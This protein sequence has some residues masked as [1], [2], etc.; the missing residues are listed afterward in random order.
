MKRRGMFTVMDADLR[1]NTSAHVHAALTQRT[2]VVCL[3]YGGHVCRRTRTRNPRARNTS[4]I[5]MF[6]TA[7]PRGNRP[8]STFSSS[9]EAPTPTLQPHVYP[10]QSRALS[11]NKETS[12]AGLRNRLPAAD[13]DDTSDV[14]NM[15]GRGGRLRGGGGSAAQLEAF[16]K[17]ERYIF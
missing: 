7:N 4:S 1:V 16:A 2:H 5:S 9:N 6:R 17:G 11:V 14:I 3:V 12:D 13:H 15:T 8:N 10:G